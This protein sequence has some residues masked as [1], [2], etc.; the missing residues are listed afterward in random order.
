MTW[1][2]FPGRSYI[3]EAW[4]HF[5]EEYVWWIDPSWQ[6]RAHTGSCTLLPHSSSRREKRIGRANLRKLMD[7]DKDSLISKEVKKNNNKAIHAKAI[8]SQ[9]PSRNRLWK[10]TSQPTSFYHHPVLLLSMILFFM[11]YLFCQFGSA[12]LTVSTP[13]LLLTRS[14]L[15]SCASVLEPAHTVSLNY[16]FV[17]FSI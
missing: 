11:E 8:S 17:F 4:T 13:S 10:I 15:A 16:V 5:L 9:S 1:I 2:S 7:W 12:I 3:L 6:Q 14:L